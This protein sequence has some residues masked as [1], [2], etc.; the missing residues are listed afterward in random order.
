M[1]VKIKRVTEYFEATDRSL[2][3][4]LNLSVTLIIYNTF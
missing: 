2:A 4:R 1:I 3:H